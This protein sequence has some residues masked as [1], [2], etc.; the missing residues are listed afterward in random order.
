M[1]SLYFMEDIGQRQLATLRNL[2]TAGLL[3]SVAACGGGGNSVFDEIEQVE[4]DVLAWQEGVYLSKSVYEDY[5]AIP[6]TGTDPFN[7]NQPYPDVQGSVADENFF[8]RSWTNELYLWYDEVED[9]D[10][11]LFST[12]DYFDQLKTNETTESGRAKDNFHFSQNTADYLSGTVSGVSFGYGMRLVAPATSPP[13][14]FRVSDVVPGSPADTAGIVRGMLITAIDG[15]DFINGD[16]LDTLNAGLS[17]SEVGESHIF[18]MQR[19][20]E[21]T[22][23]DFDLVSASVTS[24]P[25]KDVQVIA[26]ASGDVG[27]IHFNSHIRPS[28]ADLFDA[29]TSLA[30]EGVDDLV[31]DL[32]YNGGGLLA[33]AGQVA[34]MVA[35]AAQ[36]SGKTFYLTTFN[37][38]HTS[39]DP[40][41]NASLLPIPFVDESQGFGDDLGFGV[42]LP[43]LNLSRVFILST[44]STCSASE[45]IINGLIG[46]DV[47][48]ILI[49]GTTCGKPY[50]FYPQD[51]C[52]TT[53]FSVQFTGVN[54]DGFGEYSDGFSPANTPNIPGIS[55]TGCYLED[56]YS[57]PLGS[58]QEAMLAAALQYREDQSCP[59]VSSNKVSPSVSS[60]KLRNTE[61]AIFLPE[62]P[63][64]NNAILNR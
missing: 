60:N 30:T 42:D 31:L 15:A 45:A 17:P 33:I 28:E 20:D 55:V 37:D 39:R 16:D 58:P 4:G 47:E 41:T 26:T 11:N 64:L 6:R 24:V 34:Y 32:R 27:Y 62:A 13:R 36:T 50:G 1:V 23:T 61:N 57:Q 7:N 44:G 35:G 9:Q 63:G 43:A 48:V 59:S 2:V 12:A 38:Q 14:E 46:A 19:F 49:G 18:S 8:L 21:T 51:N 52:G 29:F 22:S 3:V 56:D 25:V 40:V 54:D 10:P 53:Y 5:C